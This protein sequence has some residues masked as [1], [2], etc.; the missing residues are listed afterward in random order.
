MDT[1][2]VGEGSVFVSKIVHTFWSIPVLSTQ[3]PGEL[4]EEGEEEIV[5]DP[6]EEG[7]VVDGEETRDKNGTPS[8]T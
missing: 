2:V 6:G 3:C 5:E 7:G 8:E 4:G 1:L